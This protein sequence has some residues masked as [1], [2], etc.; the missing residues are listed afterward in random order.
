M[1][2]LTR[3]PGESIRIGDGIIVKV[4]ESGTGQVKLGISAPD[5]MPIHREEIY[6][7]IRA[8]N[9]S[10]ADAAESV[11]DMISSMPEEIKSLTPNKRDK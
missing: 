2:V 5:S 6:E 8:E 1:L 11:D 10:A 7:R 4:L 9:L 3:K